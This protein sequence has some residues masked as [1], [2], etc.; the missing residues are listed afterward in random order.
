MCESPRIE[1]MEKNGNKRREITLGSA[2]A[3]QTRP[4]NRK[5]TSFSFT[6][7]VITRKVS[8]EKDEYLGKRKVPV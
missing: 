2:V 4:G 5:H 1:E 7:N 3:E 8:D 6:P